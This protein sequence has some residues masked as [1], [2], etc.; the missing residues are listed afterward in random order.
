M[1][2]FCGGGGAKKPTTTPSND[3]RVAEDK[4]V[5][6]SGGVKLVLVGDSFTGKTCLV[7]RLLHNDFI[8]TTPTIGAA[9][10]VHTLKVDGRDI[11]LE[12]WDTAGQEKFRALTPMYYRGAAAA[13]VVYDITKM[14]T[15]E[16]MKRWIDELRSHAPPNIVL[17]ICGN[18]VDLED[19]RA[20]PTALAQ[21]YVSNWPPPPSTSPT[22]GSAAP[23]PSP[24]ASSPVMKPVF[25]EVSAKTGQNV[26]ELLTLL[27]R[28]LIV[29]SD[30]GLL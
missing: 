7:G 12:I 21:Q 6:L 13:L 26:M 8:T 15:F 18:K 23:P 10:Q 28:Q 4:K 24:S 22:G 3:V 29:A 27:G 5:S 9:F 14:A 20:V 30:K 25:M 19:A 16:V 2:R 17:A 1:G 11:K